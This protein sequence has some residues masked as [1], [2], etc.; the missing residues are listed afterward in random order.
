MV[1]KAGIIW[2]IGMISNS[3]LVEATIMAAM[4]ECDR[5][6]N[7][8]LNGIDGGFYG[9]YVIHA[10]REGILEVAKQVQLQRMLV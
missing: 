8:E 3:D 2:L 10:D 1:K 5:V 4:C 9:L 6:K 7:I